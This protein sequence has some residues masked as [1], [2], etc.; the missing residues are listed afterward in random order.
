MFLSER[1]KI[2][3]SLGRE[4]GKELPKVEGRREK[5]VKMFLVG[6]GSI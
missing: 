6:L 3:S 2:F 1:K 4:S 5:L